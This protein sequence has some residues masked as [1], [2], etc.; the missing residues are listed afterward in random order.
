MERAMIIYN[1]TPSL[2]FPIRKET[3]ELLIFYDTDFQNVYALAFTDAITLCQYCYAYE[4]N[5]NFVEIPITKLESFYKRFQRAGI[6]KIL[7]NR[8]ISG[9]VCQAIKISEDKNENQ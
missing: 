9:G 4:V 8:P 2:L 3:N 7:I 1:I 6:T 5:S